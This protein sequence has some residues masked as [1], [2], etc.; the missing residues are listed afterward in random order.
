MKTKVLQNVFWAAMLL[1]SL[2]SNGAEKRTL[3]VELRGVYGSRIKLSPFNG[4]KVSVP[5]DVK[6]GVMK[7]QT[8]TFSVPDSLLPGEFLLRCDYKKNEDSS[9][10]PSEA[11]LF[12]NR[13]NVK[14]NIHPMY[15]SADSLIL[16]NDRENVVWNDFEQRDALKR[17]QIALLEQLLQAYDRPASTVW[18]QAEKA[19]GERR[20]EYNQWLDSMTNAYSHL[21]V[22]HLF[23][24]QRLPNVN[25][26]IVPE[27]RLNEQIK[28]WF[29][30]F[31]FNDTLAL[32]SR[33][34]NQYINA[35]VGLFGAMATTIELR[36]SLF[37]AAGSM[38]C[39]KAAT[40]NPK[41]Y[42]WIVDYFFNGYETYDITAGLQMLEKHIN[43][44][45]CLTSKKMEIARRLE[46]MK[47]LVPGVKAPVL[48]A[49]DAKGNEIEIGMEQ[50]EKDYQ[51]LIFYA[52]DCGHCSELFSQLKE[53]YD[54]PEN[55]V[56]FKITSIAL[57]DI[58]DTWVESKEN[59][60]LPW[61]DFYAPNGVNSEAASNY[62]V[63]ST[64]SLFIVDKNGV[65]AGTPGSVNDLN[66]FLNEGDAN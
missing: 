16:T 42:G 17:Q 29:N 28:N 63:L 33:Q 64:P 18:K 59:K 57:D 15:T 25:W 62:Y 2:V 8:V 26:N 14:V 35:Y 4:I 51:L 19:Y 7:G 36:D 53:W 43:N 9:P 1:F 5:I 48:R 22:G 46:G 38:A 30:D 34:M 20:N 45:H 58:R 54:V 65:L 66:H 21:Y 55:R 12:L 37:T 50:K 11:R 40:G 23:R 13:E 24:F 41:V 52:S 31:D 61:L 39:E 10:Y 60:D 49:Q 6:K 47:K 44:P 27:K 56:W 32:R 3:T